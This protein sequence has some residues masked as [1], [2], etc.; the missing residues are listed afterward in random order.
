MIDLHAHVLPGVDDGP[1]TWDET[2]ALVRAA[3]GAGVTAMAATPHML[4][5]G[6]WAN[7]RDR[8]LPLVDE[9]RRRVEREGL[10]VDIVPGGEVYVVPDAA[11]RV[12]KGKA[13][14]Y[15]DAGRYMLLELPPS[16]VPPYLERV[17]F[18][19]RVTGVTPIIAHPER[20]EVVQRDPDIVWEWHERGALLQLNVGSLPLAGPLGRTARALLAMGAVHLLASDAHG[21]DRRPPLRL[22]DFQRVVALAGELAARQLLWDNPAAVLAGDPVTPAQPVAVLPRERDRDG[23]LRRLLRRSRGFDED[24]R[25]SVRGGAG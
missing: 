17:L 24:S 7:E 16:H 1:V 21:L 10:G 18:E 4:P 22:K 13:M 14:T 23:W 5:D 6:P 3:A 12:R 19:L 11:E 15:G 20:Y 8:I 25:S 9:L 2:L